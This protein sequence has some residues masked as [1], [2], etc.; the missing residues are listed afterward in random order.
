MSMRKLF[1]EPL[2]H[3]LVLGALM[4]AGYAWLHRGGQPQA[5]RI[6]VTQ[7]QIDNLRVTFSRVWQRP[8]TPS[9]LE[10][11][12][13]DTIREE[14]LARGARALGLDRDDTVIRRRLRQKMEF[15]SN[16]LAAPP[17]PSDA[18]LK[19]FL[20]H[21]P[22]LFR[23][24]SRITVR[25]VFLN[26][27]QRGDALQRDAARMLAELN[28]PGTTADFRTLGDPT[29]LNSELTDAPVSEVARQFGEKFLRQVEHV[30]TGHW[31]GPVTS[32]YGDHLVLVAQ[33]TPGRTPALAEIRDQ[34]ASEWADARR[35]E[36]N[37]RFYQTL[38]KRYVVTIEGGPSGAYG[39]ALAAQVK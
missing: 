16:D 32:A 17:A 7:G 28:R 4:F 35:R 15:I 19:E 34:V 2:I 36:D 26:P 14:V 12:I 1:K 11:L 21:H 39:D 5:G 27:S 37:E 22:D 18:Q 24:E 10:G 29:L 3:F 6:M 20:T 38:L 25:Q 13:Q 31:Q 30:P 33:R 8:P 23:I 9:E